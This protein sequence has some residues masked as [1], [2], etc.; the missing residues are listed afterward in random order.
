[1]ILVRQYIIVILKKNVLKF[2]IREGKE[3]IFG[4]LKWYNDVISFV[5]DYISGS[6]KDSEVSGFYRYNIGFKNLL[7]SIEFGRKAST[8]GYRYLAQGYLERKYQHDFIRYEWL[9]KEYRNQTFNFL[10][11]VEREYF[12][13]TQGLYY[14][15]AQD[16]ITRKQKYER[17]GLSK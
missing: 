5:L 13:V 14:D 9:R 16:L 11:E 3:G 7:R 2:Q 6:I 8:Y 4:T 1:M 12:S 15:T 17:T 10:P